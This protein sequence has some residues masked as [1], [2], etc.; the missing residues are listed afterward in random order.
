MISK[1]ASWQKSPKT[2]HE[3]SPRLYIMFTGPAPP[4]RLVQPW[5]YQ[6]LKI[7]PY[8]I[9]IKPVK[10]CHFERRLYFERQSAFI[11]LNAYQPRPSF[12]AQLTSITCSYYILLCMRMHS[13]F[14]KSDFW[15]FITQFKLPRFAWKGAHPI[16]H[17]RLQA[18]MTSS[19]S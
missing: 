5:P 11:P 8:Q 16:P 19:S 15:A 4:I 13:K 2:R 6:F 12:A 10:A 9:S 14:S 3:E 7:C 1:C 17:P 18:V